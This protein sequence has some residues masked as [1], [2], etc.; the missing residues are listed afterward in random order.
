MFTYGLVI[1]AISSLLLALSVSSA[2]FIS[3]RILQGIGSAMFFSTGTAMLASVYP[4][5][6]RGKALGANVAT[7]YLGL[8]IGPFLG[9]LLTQ[10]LGWRSIFVLNVLLCLPI[11]VA[12]IWMIKE[13][14]AEA[15]G[16][17]FDLKGSMLC[18]LAVIGILLGFSFLPAMIGTL[19]ARSW[20][21]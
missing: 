5:G 20:T 8:S 15:K 13:E 7:M 17:K 1:Y 2:M 14:W 4:L 21:L 3:L 18:G 12:I 16:D 19:L 6:E 9:G 10:H 11:L